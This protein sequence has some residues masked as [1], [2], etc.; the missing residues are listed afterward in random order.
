MITTSH[1]IVVMLAIAELNNVW[2]LALIVF[3]LKSSTAIAL[4]IIDG[5]ASTTARVAYKSVGVW[6]RRLTAG[7]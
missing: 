3:V 6:T 5:G 7:M 4:W 1:Q 2:P